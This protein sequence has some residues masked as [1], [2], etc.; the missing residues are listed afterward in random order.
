V[1]FHQTVDTYMQALIRQA[2]EFDRT[3]RLARYF[4]FIDQMYF[5]SNQG[6]LWLELL[7][8]PLRNEVD[9]PVGFEEWE[10]K[11]RSAQEELRAAVAGSTGLTTGQEHYGDEWLRNRV[12]VQVNVTNPADV[13]FRSDDFAKYINFAPDLVM[14]D[15][16]KIAFWDVT[17]LDPGS[18]G[19]IFSGA[20]IGEH[21]VGPTWDDRALLVH[22][23]A[24]CG[25]KDAARE[26]LRSQGF[27]D[28]EIPEAF[29]P[30]ERPADY[31]SKVAALRQRGWQTKAVQVHNVTGFGP[32][33][34]TVM[35]AA[36]YNLMPSGSFIFAPDS[37]WNSTL[38]GSMLFGAALR[39]CQVAV[40]CP[41]VANAP[42]DGVPQM[43]RT[44]ELFTRLLVMS[45]EFGQEVAAV[46]GS[47]HAGIYDHDVPAGD[48]A[49]SLRLLSER[50]PAN[51][52][53]REAFPFDEEVIASFVALADTLDAR[54]YSARYL[55]EDHLERKPK[56]HLKVQFMATRNVIPTL[57]SRPEWGALVKGWMLAYAKEVQTHGAVIDA[58][59]IT[60]AG[61]EESRVL[62]EK[63]WNSLSLNQR[64]HL[65]AYM[66]IGSHN[67][68]YRSLIMDGE[69]MVIV[70]GVSALMAYIDFARIMGLSTWVTKVEEVEKLLPKPT[71]IGRWMRN[72]I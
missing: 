19:A 65:A 20:G 15:H 35:K 2:R 31:E 5:E 1:G 36:Q 29:Q 48:H 34:A 57:A 54:G 70:S 16:R 23:P 64:Q 6:R 59:A 68:N 43:S 11:I 40:I 22:G 56:L 7:M 61:H 72:A 26:L 51:P 12:R 13:S 41:S 32:K 17:E 24:I 9:L 52:F 66:D 18:G 4:I 42:S 27:D 38:W 33:A 63:W 25:L 8:D 14:R 39:G 50:L 69:V 10:D 3:G 62:I 44:T 55:A 71:G 60:A 45:Q 53:L 21:Y 58:R 28:R 47:F 46:G 67:Q 49:R 37:L 30:L